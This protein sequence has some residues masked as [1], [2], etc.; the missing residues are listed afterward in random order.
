MKK[1]VHISAHIRN[2]K[3]NPSD[4]AKQLAKKKCINLKENQTIVI[5]HMKNYSLKNYVEW[6]IKIAR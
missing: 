5:E 6:V 1:L 4:S 2:I 3:G